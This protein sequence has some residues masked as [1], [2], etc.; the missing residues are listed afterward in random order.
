[1]WG[2]H[3]TPEGIRLGTQEQEIIAALGAPEQ[4]YAQGGA[5]SLYYDRRGIRFTVPD[6]GPLAGRVGAIRII[7]PAVP[8][9]D[10]L[11]V[12]GKRISNAQRAHHSRL[13]EQALGGDPLGKC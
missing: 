8:R 6:N 13:R 1:M 7:W 4:T 11:I 2:E 10:T 12:P 3:G 5:T 9:A